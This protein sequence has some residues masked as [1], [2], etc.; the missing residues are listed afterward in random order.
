MTDVVNQILQYNNVPAPCVQARP[1]RSNFAAF[2][3]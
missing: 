3:A 2:T 1:D